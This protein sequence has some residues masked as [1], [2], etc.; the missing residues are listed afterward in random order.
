MNNKI[1]EKSN[2]IS[3]EE[4]VLEI[5]EKNNIIKLYKKII[6]EANSFNKIIISNHEK[7]KKLI[8]DSKADKI[9]LNINYKKNKNQLYTKCNKIIKEI[10][11]NYNSIKNNDD[12]NLKLKEENEKLKKYIE[13]NKKIKEE[14]KKLK[15]E[16]IISINKEKIML[17][18]YNDNIKMMKYYQDYIRDLEDKNSNLRNII[19]M[20]TPISDDKKKIENLKKENLKSENEELKNKKNTITNRSK[21]QNIDNTSISSG[22]DN[23]SANQV[24][25]IKYRESNQNE[26]EEI[27]IENLQKNIEELENHQDVLNE[28]G[29][30][31]KLKKKRI[32]KKIKKKGEDKQ[33]NE[34]D[35][36]RKI[37]K[38]EQDKQIN[39]KDEQKKLIKQEQ[40]KQI[41]VKDEQRKINKQEQP[42]KQIKMNRYN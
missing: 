16:L 1:N 28:K 18:K 11:L 3:K 29:E 40:D 42:D 17:E 33:I 2:D 10:N 41:E 15:E 22:S 31:K 13:K 24:N 32:V 19:K 35:E 20:D 21:N 6:E 12:M 37:N 36:Q 23:R 7:F 25:E 26:N 34:N 39:V 14:Y 38:Q 5:K 9:K 27:S 4:Y 30:Q 8:E